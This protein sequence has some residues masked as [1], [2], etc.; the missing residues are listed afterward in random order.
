MG[1]GSPGLGAGSRNH[2]V[3][4]LWIG[5]I[6]KPTQVHP[7]CGQGHLPLSQGAPAE[8]VQGCTSSCS[9]LVQGIHPPLEIV[10]ELWWISI[11]SPPAF[12]L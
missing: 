8:Q 5:R 6:V 7:C 3:R 11:Q 2:R 4:V 10:L 9:V 1:W 12:F